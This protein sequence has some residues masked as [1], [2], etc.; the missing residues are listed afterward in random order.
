MESFLTKWERV[1]KETVLEQRPRPDPSDDTNPKKWLFGD[2]IENDTASH[3]NPTRKGI[4]VR[5]MV[6]N[7]RVNP[8]TYVELT[9]GHGNFWATSV[10]EGHALTR[11]S[12]S[13][14]HIS[15]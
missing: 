9:D 5:R 12:F 1:I 4:F 8:G 13:P 6:N 7:R 3:N 2:V 15:R 11:I 10:R 14:L